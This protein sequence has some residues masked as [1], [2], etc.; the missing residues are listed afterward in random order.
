MTQGG[1]KFLAEGWSC[2]S[3][4]RGTGEFSSG[5]EFQENSAYME[6]RS[7]LKKITLK[8]SGL[9]QQHLKQEL[10]GE[11][12]KSPTSILQRFG[13]LLEAHSGKR[14]VET[15]GIGLQPFCRCVVWRRF[16]I[17]D[18]GAKGELLI[19]P[20]EMFPSKSW[21]MPGNAVPGVVPDWLKWQPREIRWP[22]L[23]SLAGHSDPEMC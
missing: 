19:F 20:S 9:K 10:Q 2:L 12:G 5:A 13:M 4:D 18:T 1:G 7:W 15:A 16:L 23:G 21:F 11:D 8:C 14:S 6:V 3:F 17:S 22:V